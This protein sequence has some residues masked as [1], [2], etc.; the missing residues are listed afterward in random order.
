MVVNK[1]D[2]NSAIKNALEIKR[3]KTIFIN[4]NH[5]TIKNSIHIIYHYPYLKLEITDGFRV[6]ETKI[7]VESKENQEDDFDIVISDFDIFKSK[8]KE[9]TII[10]DSKNAILKLFDLQ[11]TIIYKAINFEYFDTSKVKD[12]LKEK[13]PIFEICVTPK[14]L[15]DALKVFEEKN[16]PTFISFYGEIQP[17]V[18][19]GL[20][21]ENKKDENIVLPIARKK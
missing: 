21:E 7:M 20:Q 13:E 5:E 18:I 8:E 17:I 1:K 4:K 2:W 19:T 11:N 3:T 16:T 6:H 15:I 10:Y 9:I 14:F 12:S